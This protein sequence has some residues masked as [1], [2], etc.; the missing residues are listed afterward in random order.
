MRIFQKIG[1]N[2]LFKI[3][4]F[5]FFFYCFIGII[6]FHMDKRLAV[7]IQPAVQHTKT[8]HK[9]LRI[10]A[11]ICFSVFEFIEIQAC[12][13]RLFIQSVFCQFLQ[14]FLNCF[15]KF[16]LLFCIGIFRNDTEVWLLNTILIHAVHIF[17]D[18]FI[19]ERLFQRCSRCRTNCIIQYIECYG[20][21]FIQRIFQ[22]NI[23]GQIGIVLLRFILCN[24]IGTFHFLHTVKRLLCL[25]RR[26]NF[27]III[28]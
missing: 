21:L 8:I 27:Q 20:K 15:Y 18:A 17:S 13:K 19:N 10:R 28:F 11:E 7:I 4:G 9:S 3:I 16:F 12:V 14:H 5:D 25:N 2:Q 23:V 26:I 1:T 6:C 24:R 22:H